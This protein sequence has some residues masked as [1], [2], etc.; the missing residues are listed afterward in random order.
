MVPLRKNLP[1]NAASVTM[2]SAI[3]FLTIFSLFLIVSLTILFFWF[4][5]FLNRNAESLRSQAQAQM[6]AALQNL[7]SASGQID[8]RL[9]NSSQAIQ[10]VSYQLGLLSQA[11]EK[12]FEATKTFSTLEEIL[13]PPKPRGIMGEIL[14][15][16]IL[17]EILP[18]Q[19]FYELQHVFKDGSAV[20]AIIRLKDGLIP[21]DAKF[22]LDNFRR[23]IE[24]KEDK[25]QKDLRKEFVRNVK[26]HIET[27]SQKY[28]LPDEGTLPFALMYVPAE[29]VY[30]EM[31]IRTGWEDDNF[32]LYAY[33]TRKHVFPVSPNSLYPYLMTLSLGLRGLKIETRTK[34]ILSQLAR[35]NSD[36]GR[37]T[38]DFKLVGGHLSEA[39][40]KY[41]DATKRLERLEGKFSNLRE[42]TLADGALTISPEPS[43]NNPIL[44]PVEKGENAS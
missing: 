36:L 28:I 35:L 26:K 30:Y 10:N 40:K 44:N 31:I 25:E 5:R 18:T 41:A 34:E 14:L 29:N 9:E 15:E 7:Q 13:K 38:N 33:A 12:I 16:N 37:F 3:L 43:E 39:G 32:D 22:P 19:E 6:N 24:S 1:G 20:D 27:I 23:M 42:G 8:F 11:T 21:I 2:H 4:Y 17:R